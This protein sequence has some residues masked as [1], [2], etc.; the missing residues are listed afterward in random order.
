MRWAPPSSSST[1]RT[2]SCVITSYSIHYT[3]LYDGRASLV[4]GL[5]MAGACS[6]LMASGL[7]GQDPRALALLHRITSYNVC[8][9]KLLRFGKLPFTST[10]EAVFNWPVWYLYT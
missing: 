7:A 10:P 2:W 4:R 9:T 6:S 3:K 5:V 8:Y 1:L